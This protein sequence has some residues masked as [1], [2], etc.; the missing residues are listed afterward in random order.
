MSRIADP[1]NLLP[2]EENNPHPKKD[3]RRAA[4]EFIASHPEVYELFRRFAL[5]KLARGQR[6]GAKQLAERV[7]WEVSMSWEEDDRGFRLNNNHTSY[8][9]RKLVEEIPELEDLM[10]FRRTFY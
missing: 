10:T 7:R 1:S 6:F 5:Q 8:I 3:L 2:F 9:A 4:E